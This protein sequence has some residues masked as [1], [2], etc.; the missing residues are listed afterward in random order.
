MKKILLAIIAVLLI[1]AGYI[2]HNRKSLIK[3]QES[4]AS[5][6]L[7]FVLCDSEDSNCNETSSIPVGDYILNEEKTYCEGGGKVSDYD[8]AKGTIKYTVKGNDEC[9]LYFNPIVKKDPYFC[10]C[11]PNA[12]SITVT[13]C[14][15]ENCLTGELIAHRETSLFSSFYYEGDGEYEIVASNSVYISYYDSCNNHGISCYSLAGLNATS[16]MFTITVTTQE[17]DNYNASTFTF[18]GKV[19]EIGGGSN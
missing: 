14:T 5:S 11:N 12:S 17:T 15:K 8:S 10:F 7:T 1:M 9:K 13:E 4:K 6:H 16:N 3:T 18:D 2:L 19:T